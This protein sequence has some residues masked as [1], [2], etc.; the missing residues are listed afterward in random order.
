MRDAE[1]WRDDN[2]CQGCGGPSYHRSSI[3]GLC[4]ECADEAFSPVETGHWQQESS[5]TIPETHYGEGAGLFS[6]Q[7]GW[8]VLDD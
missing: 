2:C 3:D 4:K 1:L 5:T 7:D 8:I 6:I